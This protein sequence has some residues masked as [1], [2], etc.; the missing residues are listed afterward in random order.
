LETSEQRWRALGCGAGAGLLLGLVDWFACGLA[1]TPTSLALASLGLG[2]AGGFAAGA[3]AAARGRPAL[4]SGLVLAAGIALEGLS[5][6]SKE[7]AGSGQ[8][9][10]AAAVLL[11]AGLALLGL[12]RE[13]LGERWPGLAALATLPSAG[14]LAARLTESPLAGIAACAAPLAWIALARRA[15][16]AVLAAA[17]LA[18]LALLLAAQ[19]APAGPAHRAPPPATATSTGPSVVLLVIDTLRADALDPTGS[20][21]SF[22]REGV[23][24]RQCVSA[25]PWT[26]P[27]VSSLLTGLWPSQHGAVTAATPLAEEVTT[28]AELLHAAGYATGAFT[29][30]AFV[31]EGHRLDQGF[32]AFEAGCERR[33]APFSLRQPLVW[34]LAKNRHFPLRPLVRAVDESVGLAGVLAAARAWAEGEPQRP[35]FLFLHTYQVHDYYLYDPDLD[36][37]VLAAG[38]SSSSRFAGRLSVPPREFLTASQ[39]DLDHFH[40]L[41]RGRVRVV[42]E[43][44]PALVDTLEPLVGADALWIVTADHG[45]GFDAASGRVH[46]GGRLHED[47]LRVP[48]LLRMPGRLTPGQVVEPSVRSVDVL[49]TV[50]AL[51]GLPAPQGLAGESLLPAL[52][53]ERPYPATAFAE[54]LA[55]GYGLFALRQAGWK[56]IRAPGREELYRL[57][58]DPAERT[59]VSGPVPEALRA[60]A[61]TFAERFPP[62]RSAEVELDGTTLEQLRALGYVH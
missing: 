29:G 43:L 61:R 1:A 28:L 45:E 8:L 3:L 30:G 54:E 24:F 19:R 22:A 40:A 12:L 31:G 53:G 16:P 58:E 48:L 26:L 32:E 2:L 49:P 13:N 36:D 55:H 17:L 25:A 52:A 20:L 9:V 27:A 4:A 34:R 23:E 7:L 59:P 38:P 62:R 11:V 50:L 15:R 33:F 47:L 39:A 5:I 37:A 46:H 18:P 56:W 21:A 44:F 57:D 10:A 35:K 60:E 51:L 6:A 42:E 14:W 41:Y